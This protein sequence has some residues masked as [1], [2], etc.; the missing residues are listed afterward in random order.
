MPLISSA[1]LTGPTAG[2][3]LVEQVFPWPRTVRVDLIVTS[4]YNFDAVFEVWDGDGTVLTD[5]VIPVLG[6]TPTIIQGLGPFP[7]PTNGRL[8]LLSRNTPVA[9]GPIEV[10]GS[11]SWRDWAER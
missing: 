3:V 2:Q 8:R 9:P 5:R 6:G 4:N 7:M 1:T 11:I 10:Q